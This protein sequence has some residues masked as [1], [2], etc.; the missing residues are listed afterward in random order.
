M[1]QGLPFPNIVRGGLCCPFWPSPKARVWNGLPFIWMPHVPRRVGLVPTE[2]PVLHYIE[3][4]V[5]NARPDVPRVSKAFRNSAFAFVVI[6]K[7]KPFIRICPA[8]MILDPLPF[9]VMAL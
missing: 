3:V 5:T 2:S 4:K 9:I 1:F 8:V 7:A 6:I